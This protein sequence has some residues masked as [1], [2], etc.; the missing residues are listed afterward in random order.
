MAE[1]T[2]EQ[3]VHIARAN[4]VRESLAEIVEEHR[5]EILTRAKAKLRA[6]GIKLDESE[7]EGESGKELP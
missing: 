6:K 1:L 4:A 7:L 5:A 2:E 3:K